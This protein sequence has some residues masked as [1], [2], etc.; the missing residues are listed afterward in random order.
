MLIFIGL[1]LPIIFILYC[2]L[3][4]KT[5]EDREADDLAQEEYLKGWG[6]K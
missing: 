6:K 3:A 2:C 4:A 5:P 1:F